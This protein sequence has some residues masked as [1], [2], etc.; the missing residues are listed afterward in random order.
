MGKDRE[1]ALLLSAAQRQDY[2]RIRQSYDVWC[3][4]VEG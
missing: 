1:A 3:L 4:L 2:L